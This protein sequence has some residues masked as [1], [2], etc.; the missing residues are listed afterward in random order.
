VP[1]INSNNMLSLDPH[2][3]T[4]GVGVNNNTGSVGRGNPQQMHGTVGFM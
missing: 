3:S 1:A 4:G 2:N